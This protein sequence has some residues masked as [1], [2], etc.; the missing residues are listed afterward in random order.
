LD[1]L[2]TRQT[3]ADS[4][5]LGKG[6]LAR[7]LPSRSLTRLLALFQG[8]ITYLFQTQKVVSSALTGE[9]VVVVFDRRVD[10]DAPGSNRPET[11]SFPSLSST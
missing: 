8:D 9:S 4:V 11:D 5:I 1:V 7:P 6:L 10:W 2:G 3:D